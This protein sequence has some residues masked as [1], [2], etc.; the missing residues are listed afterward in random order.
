MATI[1]PPPLR[2]FLLAPSVIDARRQEETT[3][4]IR[5]TSPIRRRDSRPPIFR[6]TVFDTV[7][8]GHVRVFGNY[9]RARGDLKRIYERNNAP[10][11][12]W[13]LVF[14]VSMK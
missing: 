5:A 14:I 3:A 1:P 12:G 2:Y 13:K 7:G 6:R 11:V 4:I 8:D 10:R 9:G